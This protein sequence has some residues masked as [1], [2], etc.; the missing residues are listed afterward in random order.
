MKKYSLFN[1]L[2]ILL[3]TACGGQKQESQKLKAGKW[4]GEFTAEKNNIPFTFEVEN[5]ASDSLPTLVTLTNGEERV[6]IENIS[7]SGDTVTIYIKEYDTQLQGVLKGDTLKG[8]FRRL[9]NEEDKGTPF[10]AI[11]G[12]IPRFKTEGTASDSLAGKWDIQFI[13]ENGTKNNVGIFAGK[14]GI[15]TGS[16]LTNS[17]DF[18]YLEGVIDADGFRLSAFAGLSAYL[19]KG[20]FTDKDNFEGEFISTRG[21][22]KIKGTRNNKAALSNPYDL[23][24][25]KKGYKTLD[26]KFPNLN[27]QE[28]SLSDPEFK[29]KVV[30][31]SILGSWCPNC[32]DEMAFLAPWYKENKDRGI[33]IIGLAFERKD[34]PEYVKK[35]L[36]NLI[37]K[38]DTSYEVL[39][40][41]KLGD[42]AKALPAIDGVKTYPTTIFIDKKGI[43]RKIHTGF[44]GPATG[45]F[46]DE[47]KQEFNKLVDELVNEK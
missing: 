32:L 11:Y 13:S 30:I 9:F 33:E 27:G 43:V 2:L 18:R 29:D 44:S 21:V 42:E 23:T 5:T 1:I 36:S 25:L 41:G 6:P 20:S 26:F 3:L 28:V 37:K 31:I 47:F 46:Y 10:R 38:Y 16:I 7:Y 15:L 35:V 24:T 39:I 14:D 40:A 34:D 45:L 8:I 19:I 4:Y 22:Q 12:N 17:G